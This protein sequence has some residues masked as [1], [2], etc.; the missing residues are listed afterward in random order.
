MP[1]K[2]ITLKA[3]TEH[4]GVSISLPL[5]SVF[6][7]FV[8]DIEFFSLEE[9]LTDTWR[10]PDMPA[11]YLPFAIYPDLFPSSDEWTLG[12]L[13]PRKHSTNDIPVVAYADG[14]AVPFASAPLAALHRIY[15]QQEYA[16]LDSDDE[17]DLADLDAFAESAK[18]KIVGPSPRNE[19]EMTASYLGMDKHNLFALTQASWK[20][21]SKD[22]M[23]KAV[24][25]AP[26]FFDAP[27]LAAELFRL[28][29]KMEEAARNYWK[30]MN[31]GLLASSDPDL[32]GIEAPDGITNPEWLQMNAKS[33]WA[34]IEGQSSGPLLA[35][36][37]S[38]EP[39]ASAPRMRLSETLESLGDMEGAE[40]ELEN[41]VVLAE[42][43]AAE[44]EAQAMQVKL[45]SR[46]GMEVYARRANWA[47]EQN[48]ELP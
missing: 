25:M 26:W 1:S 19:A 10:T 32:Y 21:G 44:R 14:R 39:F 36:L 13:I 9:L 37:E 2:S 11:R 20:A 15:R 7:K 5:R 48:V 35:V 27:A 4:W 29:G 46:L 34:Q 17:D 3:L 43:E 47:S 12:L 6:G 28:T 18:L 40:R 41:A 24:E 33:Y 42:N 16:L 45:Y 30:A 22:K 38:D 8:G 31:A 23:G